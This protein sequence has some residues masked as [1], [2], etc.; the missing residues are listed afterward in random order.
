[1]TEFYI[2]GTGLAGALFI[3]IIGSILSRRLN[4]HYS[5]FSILSIIL[6]ASA[7]IAASESNSSLEPSIFGGIIGLFDGTVCW[8]LS[9]ILKA[10]TGKKTMDAIN[11][12]TV[13]AVT[14]FGGLVSHFAALFYQF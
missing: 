2:F 6:Y 12:K 3:T 5:W 11:L 9:M 14:I 13:L 1:M 10:N 7:G 4:F 8:K